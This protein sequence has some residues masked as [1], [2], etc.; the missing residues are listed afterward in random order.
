MQCARVSVAILVVAVW[1]CS[2]LRYY[3]G[4]VLDHARQYTEAKAQYR[5]AIDIHPLRTIL[6]A[7]RQTAGE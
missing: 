3:Y 6:R 5:Q 1:G 4:L 2:S 7:T